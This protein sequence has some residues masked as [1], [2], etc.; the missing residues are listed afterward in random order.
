MDIG[1]SGST[2]STFGSDAI[3]RMNAFASLAF[4]ARS[5]VTTSAPSTSRREWC[6][7]AGSA[8]ASL[9]SFACT[10]IVD[11]RSAVPVLY[12]MINRLV[13]V[14]GSILLVC[15]FNEVASETLVELAALAAVATSAMLCA[16]GIAPE[17]VPPVLPP[18]HAASATESVI[19]IALATIRRGIASTRLG[20]F[21]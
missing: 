18:P 11:P 13:C 4:S 10:A 15:I 5:V 1:V 21:W 7:L 12:L 14:S 17:V 6:A 20:L 19:P 16:V 2:Y 8:L 9:S 3:A